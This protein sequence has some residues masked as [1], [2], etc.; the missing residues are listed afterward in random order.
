MTSYAIP[1]ETRRCR[2]CQ[3]ERRLPQDFYTDGRDATG[4]LRH[5]HTCKVCCRRDAMTRNG[6]TT[7]LAQRLT[8]P[9]DPAVVLYR[10][11]KRKASP[12]LAR[13]AKS[14][15]TQSRALMERM[16]HY[17]AGSFTVGRKLDIADEQTYESVG[18]WRPS[19]QQ[20]LNW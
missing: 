2:A 11:E 19:R 16:G 3:T 5:R 17:T 6:T 9:L 7:R 15:E 10:A 14:I 1:R 13:R 4:Q 12:R 18:R 20:K 8:R